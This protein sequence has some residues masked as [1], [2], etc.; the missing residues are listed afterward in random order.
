MMTCKVK[1]KP[2]DKDGRNNCRRPRFE[3]LYH[4]NKTI[5]NRKL[6][7]YNKTDT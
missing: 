1:T 7:H 6:V 2:E 3:G 4:C 5:Y